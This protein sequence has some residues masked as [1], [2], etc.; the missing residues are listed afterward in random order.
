MNYLNL[1]VYSSIV[2]G[3]ILVW[4]LIVYYVIDIIEWWLSR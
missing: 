2:V 1:L 3:G 4:Y